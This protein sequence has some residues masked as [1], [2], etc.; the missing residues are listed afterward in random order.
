MKFQDDI[1]PRCY[2]TGRKRAPGKGT[3]IALGFIALIGIGLLVIAGANFALDEPYLVPLIVGIAALCVVFFAALI[4]TDI[5]AES[6]DINVK[7]KLTDEVLDEDLPW[8][9]VHP[10]YRPIPKK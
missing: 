5:R 9:V 6:D 7:T 8:A 2:G 10:P 4:A 3:A 1:C